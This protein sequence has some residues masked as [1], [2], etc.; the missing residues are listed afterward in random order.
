MNISIVIPALNESGSIQQS[1]DKAWEAGGDEVIVADGGSTDGTLEQIQSCRC[2]LVNSRP[3]RAIQMNEGARIAQ[4]DVILFLHADNWLDS[5]ACDQ[6]RNNVSANRPWGGFHQRIESQGW[7]YRM[8]ESGNAIRAR[9][10]GL[11]YGDQGLF[12]DR[13]LFR[14]MGGFPEL[15]LMEDYEVSLQ[16]T[17]RF[18]PLIL[19]GKLHVSPRRWKRYGVVR[20]TVRNWSICR[21]YRRGV[22]A[23]QLASRY[24]RHDQT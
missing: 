20:Q 22:D 1:V 6:I 4:A 7:K 18:R 15:P 5:G 13:K 19:P 12:F 11:V 9:W 2:Q 23:E 24:R 21:D 10:R 3:G 14:N 17:R 8:L 16:L